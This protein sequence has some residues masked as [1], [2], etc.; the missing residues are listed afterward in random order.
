MPG[1]LCPLLAAS[2]ELRVT[3][4]GAA[5]QRTVWSVAGHR[6]R[7]WQGAVVPVQSPSEF[8]IS[9]EITTWRWPMEG[10][11][12]LDDITY[13]ARVGCY[14]SPER[15]VEEKPSG[16]FV[17]E[18]VLSLLLAL[19]VVGLVAA[20]SWYCLKQRGVASR[21]PTESNSPQGFD[22]ITFRDVRT[23]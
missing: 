1:R 20:G 5:G 17:A 18:V 4:Q 15:P 8:Q 19:V 14:S 16:N 2:G 6:S 12:A 3:L 7:G 21:T 9:F 13:S 23:G 22:N 10:T 11:V